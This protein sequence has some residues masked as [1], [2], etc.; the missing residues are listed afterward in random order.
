[1]TACAIENGTARATGA[2]GD[3]ADAVLGSGGSDLPVGTAPEAGSGSGAGAGAAVAEAAGTGVSATV[4]RPVAARPVAPRVLTPRG[5][6]RRTGA[7]VI[8]APGAASGLP[9]PFA[10]SV[11]VPVRPAPAL[12]PGAS[13][14]PG[15]PGASGAPGTSEALR[16]PGAAR[17]AGERTRPPAA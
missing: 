12:P 14:K 6:A 13:G 15:V 16:A 1:M 10:S 7:A 17:S 3:A 11:S 8:A 2:A 5:A 9:A 4:A